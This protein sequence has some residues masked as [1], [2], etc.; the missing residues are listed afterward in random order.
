MPLNLGEYYIMDRE[1][2]MISRKELE[3]LGIG[4][5]GM[6]DEKGELIQDRDYPDI[7]MY[8][9]EDKS[10]PRRKIRTPEV[11]NNVK[12]EIKANLNN[13]YLLKES[14]VVGNFPGSS[15][16]E[17]L[18]IKTSEN[19]QAGENDLEIIPPT[20]EFARN[21]LGRKSLR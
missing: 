7:I 6:I 10:D 20:D 2:E 11:F 1:G 13:G 16:E 15:E 19:D 17:R 18:I 21:L 8:G 3:E 14:E 5:P 9:A 12:E 4:L